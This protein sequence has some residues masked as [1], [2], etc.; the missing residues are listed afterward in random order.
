M[1]IPIL[2]FLI[3]TLVFQSCDPQRKITIRN[4][5]GDTA[6]VSWIIKKDSFA[7][8]PFNL[9]N[10]VEADFTLLADKPFN[11]VSMSFGVGQW[12]L[13]ALRAVTDDL[14]SLTIKWKKGELKMTSEDEIRDFLLNRRKGIGK[15]KIRILI[16]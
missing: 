15:R 16:Q 9:S 13:D 5:T 6:F 3:A 1:K 7:R 2:L 8:S 11:E 10:A 12:T 4:H 14:E